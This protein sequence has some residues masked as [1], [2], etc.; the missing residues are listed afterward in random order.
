MLIS[1]RNIFKEYVHFVRSDYKSYRKKI[2]GKWY[3]IRE[4]DVS[5]FAG[6]ITYW[7]QS[8]PDPECDTEIETEDYSK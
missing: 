3:K 4:H 1:M 2:G 8:E 5:G 7:T 6:G